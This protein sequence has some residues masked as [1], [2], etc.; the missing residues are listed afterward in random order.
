MSMHPNL[1]SKNKS[2]P[3]A[4]TPEQKV[5]QQEKLA[6][7]KEQ[8]LQEQLANVRDGIGWSS[9]KVLASYFDVSRQR[10]WIWAKEGKLPSPH[11]HGEATT[12]WNNSEVQQ[13]EYENFLTGA[14]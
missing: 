8:R 10:I 5:E 13:A 3:V 14:V 1:I 11:K 12:R 2:R 9:D 4:K 6:E 7:A